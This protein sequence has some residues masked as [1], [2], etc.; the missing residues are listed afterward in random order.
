MERKSV[1]VVVVVATVVTVILEVA[2]SFDASFV[3]LVY[4]ECMGGCGCFTEF[5]V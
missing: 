2:S 5:S 3:L 1:M 4:F